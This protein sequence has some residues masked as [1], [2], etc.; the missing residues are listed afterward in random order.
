MEQGKHKRIGIVMS[1]YE[2]TMGIAG[3]YTGITL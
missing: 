1:W 3:G 2:L